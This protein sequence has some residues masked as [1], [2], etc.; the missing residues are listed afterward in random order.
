MMGLGSRDPVEGC[1]LTDWL[2][3][4]CFPLD[5]FIHI[6]CFSYEYNGKKKSQKYQNNHK[7]DVCQYD[8]SL[9]H[10]GKYLNSSYSHGHAREF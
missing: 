6:I 3:K 1:G 10:V 2:M 9:F 8:Y 5:I 7:A 4:V